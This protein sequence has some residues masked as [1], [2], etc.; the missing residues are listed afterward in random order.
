[1]APHECL[2]GRFVLLGDEAFE[3]LSVRSARSIL[4]ES[5]SVQ[6][7]DDPRHGFLSSHLGEGCKALPIIAR[8]TA[9]TYKFFRVRKNWQT[10]AAPISMNI[11][12][13][14]ITPT[15]QVMGGLSTARPGEHVG[16][17]SLGSEL[18][19]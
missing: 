14:E 10:V 8:W 19:A 11:G 17:A 2:E 12:H 5:G 3:E 6:V 15:L 9:N 13:M 4:E 1:M 7:A 16:H 18:P